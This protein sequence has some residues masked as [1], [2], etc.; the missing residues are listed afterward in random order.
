MR[1]S[2]PLLRGIFGQSFLDLFCPRPTQLLTR[3]SSA[4]ARCVAAEGSESKT[5][6]RTSQERIHST[7]D[8]MAFIQIIYQVMAREG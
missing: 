8:K 2:L 6:S 1:R 3:C 4:L 7:E 5:I